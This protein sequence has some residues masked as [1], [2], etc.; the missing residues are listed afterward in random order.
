MVYKCV[1]TISSFKLAHTLANKQKERRKKN[2][3]S[4]PSFLF[5][6][7][8][9]TII[10]DLFPY[11]D[12]VNEFRYFFLISIK[13]PGDFAM[14]VEFG[15]LFD[16]HKSLFTNLIAKPCLTIMRLRDHELSE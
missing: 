9:D 10:K 8:L 14:Y 15:A 1:T 16:Y 11:V 3:F 13:F 4:A 5:F 2:V 7:S 12:E 6:F